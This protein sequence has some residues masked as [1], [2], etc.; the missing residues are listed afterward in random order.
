MIRPRAT[1]RRRFL[2][3]V[4]IVI[5]PLAACSARTAAATPT[6]DPTVQV[7]LRA[8]VRAVAAALAVDDLDRAD[9]ALQTLDADT[10]AARA[11]GR[12]D[13]AKLARIRAAAAILSA[14]LDAMTDAPVSTVTVDPSPESTTRSAPSTVIVRSGPTVT[15]IT[16]APAPQPTG[17][18]GDRRGQ[19]AGQTGDVHQGTSTGHPNGNDRNDDNGN[20]N[21]GHGNAV[22]NQSDDQG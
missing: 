8:D 11:A 20:D 4:L 21:Q 10:A 18:G 15:V 22:G 3:L 19:G 13:A 16:T 5:G 1:V 14:D 17:P 6:T 9:A 2:A 7:Q 12:L